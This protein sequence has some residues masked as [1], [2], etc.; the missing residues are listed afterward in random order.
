MVDLIDDNYRLLQVLSRFG[1]SLGF[2]NKKWKLKWLSSWT[3]PLTMLF[4]M[5]CAVVARA[6]GA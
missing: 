4:G 2:G 3:L 5:A 1:M 6:I